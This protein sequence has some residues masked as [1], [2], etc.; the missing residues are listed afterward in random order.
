[1]VH[2]YAPDLEVHAVVIGI[3]QAQFSNETGTFALGTRVTPFLDWI[4]TLTGE[5]FK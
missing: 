2:E 3:Y 1:M 5:L 4:K